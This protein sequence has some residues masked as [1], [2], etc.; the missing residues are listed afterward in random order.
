[1]KTPVVI[2]GSPAGEPPTSP[3]TFTIGKERVAVAVPGAPRAPGAPSVVCLGGAG[4]RPFEGKQVLITG[5]TGSLGQALVRRL[6]SGLNGIPERIVVFSRDETKQHHQRLALLAAPN[7]T[8][9]AIYRARQV[10]TFT[11][12]DVRDEASISAAVAQLTHPVIIHAAAL[13]QVPSAEYQ[14]DQAFETNVLGS[15]NVLRASRK[16]GGAYA[17][18]GVSSDKAC[19][20]TTAYGM[21]KALMERLFVAA[22]LGSSAGATRFTLVR[23]G[24]IAASRGSVIP[25]WRE[26][27][28]AGF[29]V[30]ITDERMTRFWMVIDRAVDVI[31]EALVRTPLGSVVIPEAPSC[32]MSR[33]AYTMDR[34]IHGV[35]GPIANHKVIGIRP[36]EKLHE[37]LITAAEIPFTRRLSPGYFE[38]RPLLP[39]F[40]ADYEK[41]D[42]PEMKAVV[43]GWGGAYTS[44][45]DTATS[46]EIEGLLLESGAMS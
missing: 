27:L 4:P 46:D 40:R 44:A 29:S 5:G 20:P 41:F 43:N 31:V 19:E 9:E 1:M 22:N 37:T 25:L 3:N 38:V 35:H 21:T 17:V 32:S 33:V 16:G 13:K 18:I 45:G 24:N 23:Y 14:P 2:T 34:I 28:E 15:R 30:T 39:E 7:A 10:V 26:Q 12:G 11:L 42:D 36:G 6:L 8:D